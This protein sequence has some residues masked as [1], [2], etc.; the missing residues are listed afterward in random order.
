MVPVVYGAPVEDYLAIAPP[1][2][3]IHVDWFRSAKELGEYLLYLDKNG[4]AYNEYFAWQKQ[5]RVVWDS[6]LQVLCRTC[7][8]AHAVLGEHRI[9]KKQKANESISA[10]IDTGVYRHLDRW[11]QQSSIGHCLEPG[12]KWRVTSPPWNIPTQRS[13]PFS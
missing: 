7:T 3:F 8:L 4:T 5:G 1:H 2:S 10:R 11:W 12:Q 13:S 6:H 9:W